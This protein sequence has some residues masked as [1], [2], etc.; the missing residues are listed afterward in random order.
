MNFWAFNFRRSVTQVLLGTYLL[1]WLFHPNCLTPRGV[2]AQSTVVQVGDAVC[3]QG[4]AMDY[5]CIAQGFLL[6]NPSVATLERP[7]LHS[8][9]CLIEVPECTNTPYEILF[10]PKRTTPPQD[11]LYTRGYRLDDTTKAQLLELGQTVGICGSC[12]DG[13][14]VQQGLT[15]LVQGTVVAVADGDTP[16]TIGGVVSLANP[17]NP[18]DC[19]VVVGSVNPTPTPI[20]DTPVPSPASSNPTDLPTSS[21]KSNATSTQ[22]PTDGPI[23]SKPSPA[24]SN[25]TDLPTSFPKSNLASTQ[26][27]TDG[28]T[29]PKPTIPSA[30]SG[31]QESDAPSSSSSSST[32]TWRR[33]WGS[34]LVFFHGYHIL[35]EWLQ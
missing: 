35:C 32:T 9:H 31:T 28:P 16:P 10:P 7:D 5:F 3:T 11:L 4:I 15:V 12:H 17:N 1:C 13:G 22:I 19:V 8:I 6:D 34:I 23:L 20:G 26:I 24:S 27:P 21:P 2:A 29:N 18:S 30:A 33:V 14:T 25:P